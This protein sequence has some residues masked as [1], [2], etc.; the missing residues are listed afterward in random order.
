MDFDEPLN[1]LIAKDRDTHIPM[2]KNQFISQITEATN[3]QKMIQG[4]FN[5][6][7]RW[8]DRCP[9]TDRCTLYQ[10]SS[11]LSAD[12]PDEFFKSLSMVFEATMEILKEFIEDIDSDFASI[13]SELK[14]RDTNKKMIR[15]DDDVVLAQQY[16]KQ[17]AHWFDALEKKNA[18]SMEVRL[19]DAMLADCFEVIQWYQYLLEVKMMRALMAQKDEEEEQ[20]NPYDS[21]G[22]AK[23]LLVSIERNIGAWGYMYQIFKEDEDEILDILINLQKLSRNIEEA[24]PDARAFIRPGLDDA[25][26]IELSPDS[27]LPVL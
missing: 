16:G 12:T 3:D 15:R 25:A 19:K 8:C 9:Q 22:N 4:I 27:R 11:Q 10:T 5:W 1:S 20:V 23:L 13:D 17:V 26:Q 21:L 14:R 7:D 18:Y 2:T 24:F 6:C